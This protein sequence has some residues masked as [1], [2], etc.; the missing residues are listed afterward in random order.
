[1]PR[2]PGLGG[3]PSIS[4]PIIIERIENQIPLLPAR[5]LGGLR[6]IGPALIDVCQNLL[7]GFGACEQGYNILAH[8]HPLRIDI[9]NRSLV[10][11]SPL[12]AGFHEGLLGRKQFALN[13]GEGQGRAVGIVIN[14]VLQTFGLSE[15]I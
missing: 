2:R 13:S 11:D 8:V 6:L 14:P 5:V 3:V 1:M 12:R 4:Q 15:E 10:N 9:L 7:R